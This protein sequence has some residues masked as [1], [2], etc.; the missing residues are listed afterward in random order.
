MILTSSLILRLF[1]FF[2]HKTA[3]GMRI[4]DWSS[5]VCSSDLPWD[6][7][8]WAPASPWATPSMTVMVLG[9]L[10]LAAVVAVSLARKER[11]GPVWLAAVG[12]A[13]ACQV[14]I[15][16][17]RSS[18]FTA[19]ELEIGRASCRERVVQFVSISG[20]AVSLKK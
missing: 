19:L 17:M 6:W 7:Q 3:Y 1:V 5:D 10:V 4:S 20:G 18:Q 14:P 12:Y 11:I 13:V 8:R 15:Y 9:W 16:L 2:K